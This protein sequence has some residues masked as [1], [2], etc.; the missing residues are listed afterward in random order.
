[1]HSWIRRIF[2]LHH[3]ATRRLME[4]ISCLAPSIFGHTHPPGVRPWRASRS[5][6]PRNWGGIQEPF[7]GHMAAGNAMA[8]AGGH[9]SRQRWQVQ[10]RQ[11][12]RRWRCQP[13]QWR[14]FAVE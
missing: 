5:A 14:W 4:A 1:L 6:K 11:T 8:S 3:R 2:R 10:Q 13:C 12:D 7:G 9:G